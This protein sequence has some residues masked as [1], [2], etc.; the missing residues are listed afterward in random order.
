MARTPAAT[1]LDEVNLLEL[2]LAVD[3]RLDSFGDLPAA[4][5]GKREVHA[6]KGIYE[7][8]LKRIHD[9]FVVNGGAATNQVDVGKQLSSRTHLLEQAMKNNGQ[10]D[11]VSQVSK[12]HNGQEAIADA[13]LKASA[14]NPSKSVQGAR[15][16]LAPVLE[17]Y[18]AEKDR[19]KHSGHPVFDKQTLADLTKAWTHY[20]NAVDFLGICLRTRGIAYDPVYASR[21]RV[22][23]VAR[24]VLQTS[25]E[26]EKK[27]ANGKKASGKKGE[28]DSGSNAKKDSG[29]DA[30]G[31][32]DSAQK[33]QGDSKTE[34]P[35]PAT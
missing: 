10:A 18:L 32:S 14:D 1:P 20:D 5:L 8:S 12:A 26:G 22:K 16:E 27:P 33:G 11:D 2:F 21:S 34:N 7:R 4:E 3:S 15:E 23:S 17:A 25:V 29:K 28:G 35:T 30:K 9:G 31:N 6:G 24:L 19:K 13:L